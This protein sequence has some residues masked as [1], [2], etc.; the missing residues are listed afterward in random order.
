MLEASLFPRKLASNFVFYEFFVLLFMLDPGLDPVS[1]PDPEFIT[2]PVPLRQKVAFPAPVPQHCILRVAIED[3]YCCKKKPGNPLFSIFCS[4]RSGE[5]TM[6]EE[7]FWSW[8]RAVRLSRQLITMV[9]FQFVK[10]RLIG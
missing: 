3:I 4:H 7:T 9:Y 10:F 1:E 6:K 2:I 5:E 8:L